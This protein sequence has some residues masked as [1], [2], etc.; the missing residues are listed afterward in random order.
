ML[1]WRTWFDRHIL[2]RET[3]RRWRRGWNH[4]WS[5]LG[6]AVERIGYKML[7]HRPDAT[8]DTGW[9]TL[10]TRVDEFFT[11][12][13][14][15]PENR[16][17]HAHV[18][19]LW[20]EE[21]SAPFSSANNTVRRWLGDSLLPV[22]TPAGF[23]KNLWNWKGALGGLGL[24]GLAVW[25]GFWLVPQWQ[26]HQEAK[27]AAQARLLLN[28]GYHAMA[29][30][31]AI[32]VLQKDERNPEA[33]RIL[34]DWFE[35]QNLP[36][37][38]VWRRRV[39]EQAGDSTNQLALAA[40]AVKFE[41]SP[42]ATASR[43]LSSLSGT[44]AGSLQFQ[45]VSA[46]YESRA[47]NLLAAEKHYLAARQLE[48]ANSEVELALALLR[49]QMR[50]ATRAALAEST[51]TSLSE[52]TNLSLTIRAL[53]SRVTLALKRGDFDTAEECSKRILSNESSTFED[54]LTHLEV[55]TRKRSPEQGRFQATLQEQV[56]ANPLYVAQLGGWMTSRQQTREALAWFGQLPPAIQHA[57][58]VLLATADA[59]VGAGDWEGLEQ[60][61]SAGRSGSVRQ[62]GWGT[63]E[64]LRQAL[65][66]R[67][68]RG[69][70]EPRAF[71][72]N[73]RGAKRL[74]SGMAT[75]LAK[76]HWLIATWGWSDEMEDLLWTVFDRFPNEAW[77]A[78]GLL[79]KYYAQKNTEGIRRVFAQQLKRTPNDA[80][81]KNNLAMI[82]LLRGEDLPTAHRL[83]LE[84]HQHS[85]H[86]SVNASTYAFSLLVQGNPEAG[87][88]VMDTLGPEILKVPSIAAYYAII[89]A[90]TGDLDTAR[91]HLEFV[92][93]IELFPEERALIEAVKRQL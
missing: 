70:G 51:F 9:A 17:R 59:Y 48:P 1:L 35:R 5:N 8:T 75:R 32:R 34:A 43:I 36:D 60:F 44:A 14:Y 12:R 68:H 58:L 28:R 64:F 93:Q 2:T 82:L 49:M 80:L 3:R 29:Y 20:W 7:P 78:D 53:R 61:L 56:A 62:P 71:A 38:L 76:L 90:A 89:T 52:Q 11:Q 86:S 19:R 30:Q 72:E 15:P 27:W 40:T 67:A 33:C 31:G 91:T 13:I 63:I 37:A 23:K 50:D 54:R 45:I 85:P 73:F 92:K 74:A 65:L 83:A 42:S 46:Q 69:L 6:R 18:L 57:D 81:L 16:R 25:I 55:L 21:F 4:R 22:L 87:R 24:V 79:K 10:L 66:A 47:G 41:P 88:K 84:A 77:A 39:T 26:A